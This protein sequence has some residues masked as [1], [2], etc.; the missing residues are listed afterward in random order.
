MEMRGDILWIDPTA[1]LQ[2][3]ECWL[4]DFWKILFVPWSLSTDTPI[5]WE[6]L[7]SVCSHLAGYSVRTTKPSKKKEN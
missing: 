4:V 1:L 6:V 2:N 5:R 7:I 3:P